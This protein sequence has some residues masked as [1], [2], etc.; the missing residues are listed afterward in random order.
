MMTLVRWHR[1]RDMHTMHHEMNRL[2]RDLFRG[3]LRDNGTSR[4]DGWTPAV[5]MYEDD[6]AFTLTAEL[7]GFS[8]DDVQVEIKDNR[9]TLRGERK[10]ES[11]V[12]DAQYHR[13]E[14]VYGAFRRS[15]RL[16]AMV[17]ADKAEAVFKDGVLKLTLPK[18]EEAK[19]KPI[20]ITV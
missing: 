20:S 19:P 2:V 8:K 13:V 11:E 12:K 9:L 10:R 5:D 16:P 17:D 15:I 18:A 14:R 6:A 4:R 1:A 7:P 3:G